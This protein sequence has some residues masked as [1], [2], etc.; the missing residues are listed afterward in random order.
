[1]LEIKLMVLYPQPTDL[2]QFECDY[3]KHLELFHQKMNIPT[4]EKPYEI[5]KMVST[6]AGPSPYYQM[7]SISFPSAEVLEQTLA[8]IEMQE[9]AAD[10]NRISSGG[11]P[12][13]LVGSE[14]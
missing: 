9:I 13:I 7:F 12:V 5:T 3:Q 11:N 8:S 6:P 2:N 10:A 1:M 4:D 14:V